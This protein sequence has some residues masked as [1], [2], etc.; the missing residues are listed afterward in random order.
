VPDTITSW[1]I[2]A[3]ALHPFFG[4]AMTR[5]PTELTV[6]QQFFIKS[7]IPHS[8]KL[9]EYVEIPVQIFN[10]L[11]LQLAVTVQVFCDDCTF[12]DGEDAGKGLN[13][14]PSKTYFLTYS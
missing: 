6:F 5:N 10:Y 7:S 14:L 13:L 2:S 1:H 3:F 8:V 11:D 12:M 4:L 9:G